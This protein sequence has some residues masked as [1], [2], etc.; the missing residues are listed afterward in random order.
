MTRIFNKMIEHKKKYSLNVHDDT[1]LNCISREALTPN[2]RKI[3]R[4]WVEFNGL[5][6]LRRI[7]AG[8]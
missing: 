7:L 3:V 2:E 8:E 5:P 1:Q 4:E 6:K